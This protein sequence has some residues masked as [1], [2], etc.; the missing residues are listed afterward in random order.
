MLEW[1]EW[2]A[3]VRGRQR[4]INEV[5]V[6][7]EARK[8]IRTLRDEIV[9]MDVRIGYLRGELMHRRMVVVGFVVGEDGDDCGSDGG[10][11]NGSDS[12]L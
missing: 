6:L 9:N 4:E 10:S 3:K 7:S 8:S 2:H 11:D 12:D 5:S 1:I